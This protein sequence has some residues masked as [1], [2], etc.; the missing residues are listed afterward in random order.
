MFFV[1]NLAVP[2]ILIIGG[3]ILMM[4]LVLL[5]QQGAALA[6]WAPT[7]RALFP[8]MVLLPAGGALWA[9]QRLLQIWRWRRGTL[10]GDCQRC[11]GVMVGGRCRM[12]G[13]RQ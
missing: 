3:A 12:C 6:S 13:Q 7:V 1:R 9:V 4:A 2:F 10:N 8:W 5:S 11:T